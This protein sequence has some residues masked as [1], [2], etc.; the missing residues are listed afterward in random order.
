[1]T[2]KFIENKKNKTE[3]LCGDSQT[4]N[5]NEVMSIQ[6]MKSDF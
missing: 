6:E 2:K 4:S 3:S 5:K 1:M